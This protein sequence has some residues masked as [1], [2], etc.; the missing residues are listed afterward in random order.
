MQLTPSFF[1]LSIA[2]GALYL[3]DGAPIK[4]TRDVDPSLLGLLSS[5]NSGSAHAVADVHTN[6]NDKQSASA[7]LCIG[8]TISQ[9][10]G[11]Y[12][13]SKAKGSYK[14]TPRPAP[15]PVSKPAPRPVV[16]K[17]PASKKTN[18]TPFHAP[19]QNKPVTQH[20]AQSGSNAKKVT[21]KPSLPVK[22][23][24]ASAH[25]GNGG[26]ASGGSAACNTGNN[27]IGLS[28]LNLNSC[29]GGQGAQKGG[30]FTATYVTI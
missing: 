9:V 8:G 12:H 5:S 28:A 14:G 30:H 26:F 10:N 16:N 23:T 18:R 3:V 15:K 22:T 1:A 17:K 2:L 25:G 27:L 19:Q 11:Q 24:D 6:S 7:R 4:I 21:S 29:N 20:K 13:C